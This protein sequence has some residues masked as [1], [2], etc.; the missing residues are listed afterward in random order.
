MVDTEQIVEFLSKGFN[1]VQVSQICGCTPSYVSQVAEE[2]AEDIAVARAIVT[3]QKQEIDKSLNDLEESV[4]ERLKA[5]LPFETNTTV[6]LRALQVLN[7][8][9]RKSEPEP[10]VSH[11]TTNVANQTILVMPTRFIQPVQTEDS[12]V[13]NGN[14]EIVEIEGRPLINASSNAINNMLNSQILESRLQQ[15]KQDL[16]VASRGPTAEDF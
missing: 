8:A 10:I 6:L 15:R 14:N 5:V 13:L 11:N 4:L 9:K 7:T 2:R 12:I 16:L 3:I 1:N